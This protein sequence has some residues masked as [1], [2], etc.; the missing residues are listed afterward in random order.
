MNDIPTPDL[1][2]VARKRD[3]ASAVCTREP[4]KRHRGKNTSKE[5]KEKEEEA[6]LKKKGDVISSSRARR[7]FKQQDVDALVQN[8]VRI[9][10]TLISFIAMERGLQPQPQAKEKSRPHSLVFPPIL[11][12]LNDLFV[13]QDMPSPRVDKWKG[14]ENKY[15]ENANTTETPQGKHSRTGAY[16]LNKRKLRQATRT[17]SKL[18]T[19]LN[20]VSDDNT[21]EGGRNEILPI[22]SAASTLSPS[23]SAT[24]QAPITTPAQLLQIFRLLC[25]VMLLLHPFISNVL[26]QKS[27]QEA[28]SGQSTFDRNGK[29]NGGG[30]NNCASQST[31]DR[32]SR[33]SHIRSRRKHRHSREESHTRQRSRDVIDHGNCSLPQSQ[34][35]SIPAEILPLPRSPLPPSLFSVQALAHKNSIFMTCHRL[36]GRMYQQ[37]SSLSSLVMVSLPPTRSFFQDSSSAS[38]SSSS[39]VSPTPPASLPSG[40]PSPGNDHE[41]DQDQDQDTGRNGYMH[42]G[43][44]DCEACLRGF[45]SS[46]EVVY[47]SY[48]SSA[49][50]FGVVYEQQVH[51]QSKQHKAEDKNGDRGA[52]EKEDKR[53]G[54]ELIYSLRDPHPYLSSSLPVLPVLHRGL[55][56]PSS[57]LTEGMG[58]HRH[59]LN[60]EINI[61]M[62][63]LTLSTSNA[64]ARE[65]F[66][67]YI[68][69]QIHSLFPVASSTERI[70]P[71]SLS[72]S[73]SPPL[74]S[75][76]PSKPILPVSVLVYG[77]A[78]SGLLTEESDLDIQLLIH[79]QH[80]E[81]EGKVP[82][83]GVTCKNI[84]S[85][86]ASHLKAKIQT[87]S[88][89]WRENT[90]ILRKNIENVLVSSTPSSP[91]SSLAHL[92]SPSLSPVSSPSLPDGRRLVNTF[93]GKHL[94]TR[95]PLLRLQP[96]KV[97]GTGK[98]VLDP[99]LS[100]PCDVDITAGIS[101]SPFLVSSPFPSLHAARSDLLK[102]Y[103]L[104]DDRV[105]PL[106]LLVKTWVS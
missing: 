69:Q 21:K 105:R 24:P 62:K 1:Q 67:E 35:P 92:P 4:N 84:L 90:K 98:V 61:L 77:S 104:C 48:E 17:V 96:Y 22:S 26:V 95:I 56:R 53:E 59:T 18:L 19:V 58:I 14:S 11:A 37:L 76:A 68:T 89:A 42:S 49:A 78:A 16:T 93:I 41:C 13:S 7:S 3:R 46:L 82:K 86:L 64:R 45:Q 97:Y 85:T 63:S 39:V 94:N 87:D 70:R 2:V 106:I 29:M 72:P 55:Y 28:M 9:K 38:S 81:K 15:Q 60:Q 54:K 10:G 36:I 5:K 51:M 88:R 32:N 6:R 73:L 99:F 43:S 8:L 75:M 34:L 65:H 52:E 101:Y 33:T 12:P 103:T 57:D 25:D 100:L 23:I 66:V 31:D 40:T 74:P 44:L 47:Y 83:G 91:C 79:E 30:Q 20:G 27:Q 102:R 80:D 50:Y 71:L